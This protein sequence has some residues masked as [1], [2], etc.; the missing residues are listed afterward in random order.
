MVKQGKVASAGLSHL[1]SHPTSPHH[2]TP[3]PKETTVIRCSRNP[4][5]TLLDCHHLFF[6]CSVS[7]LAFIQS[8]CLGSPL[9]DYAKSPLYTF[10]QHPLS[11]VASLH[12]F[13]WSRD[14]VSPTR[15]Q[16]LGGGTAFTFVHCCTSSTQYSGWPTG[17]NQHTFVE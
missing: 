1:S 9:F 4:H 6:C 12:L 16:A 17:R 15:R 10:I 2:P 3:L 11:I 14:Q 7:L 13:V 8:S 5:P